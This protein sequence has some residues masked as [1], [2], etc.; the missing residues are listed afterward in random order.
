M[1]NTDSRESV[2]FLPHYDQSK[3]LL[4]LHGPRKYKRGKNLAQFEEIER[5]PIFVH[6]FLG[7]LGTEQH[8]HL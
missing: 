4:N 6:F 7:D 5:D 8:N 2:H 3:D 1:V